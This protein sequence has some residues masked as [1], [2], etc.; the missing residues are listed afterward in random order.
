MELS[1]F[2]DENVGSELIEWLKLQKHKIT[3][4]K[5]EKLAGISDEKIIIKCYK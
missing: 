5:E 3:S 1:F 4:V 2:A